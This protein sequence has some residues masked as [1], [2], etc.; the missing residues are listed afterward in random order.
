MQ[1]SPCVGLAIFSKKGDHEGGAG[2]AA[3]WGTLFLPDPLFLQKSRDPPCAALPTP[4]TS[5]AVVA[6]RRCGVFGVARSSLT[7]RSR[8]KEMQRTIAR[9]AVDW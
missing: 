9:K 6:P 7:T 5:L 1:L 8:P 2:F 4:L 3:I